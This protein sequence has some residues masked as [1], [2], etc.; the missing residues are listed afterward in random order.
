ML[1][2]YDMQNDLKDAEPGDFERHGI[3]LLRRDPEANGVIKVIEDI[4]TIYIS[5]RSKRESG[6]Y[7]Y[8]DELTG[9]LP[10]DRITITGRIEEHS[11]GGS[12]WSISL[13]SVID[14]HLTHHIAP[15]TVYSISYILDEN[16]VNNALTV[17]T[18]GWGVLEPL[19]NFYVD[20]ILI[21]RA[22]SADEF[23]VDTRKGIYSLA[24]DTDLT[25]INADNFIKYGTAVILTRSGYPNIGIFKH[26]GENAIHVNTRVNDWDGLDIII[27]NLKLQAGNQ[28]KITVRGQ[29]DGEAPEGTIIMI[30]G[31]PTY[32]WRRYMFVKSNEEFTIEY[33]L[34]RQDVEQWTA[35]RIT[36]NPAGATVSFFVYGIEIERV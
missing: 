16:D 12:T 7:M 26:K 10:G 31:V 30:Q 6:I 21:T 8:I 20:N 1:V 27:S 29:I 15:G 9:L 19:M 24:T 18:I 25:L 35:A 22:D 17:H 11:L 36:T 2:L 14:G 4:K 33:N 32:S 5:G 13:F 34:T 28:Y 3:L 23:T